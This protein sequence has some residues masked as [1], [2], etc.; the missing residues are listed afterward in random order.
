MPVVPKRYITA[1]RLARFWFGDI[2]KKKN[3]FCY[4][5]C[6][7]YG[8]QNPQVINNLKHS[9]RSGFCAAQTLEKCENSGAF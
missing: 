2:K 3:R 1:T 9:S 7:V 8:K 5:R 4:R 6:F